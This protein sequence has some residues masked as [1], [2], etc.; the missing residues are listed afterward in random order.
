MTT[1]MASLQDKRFW[2][3]TGFFVLFVLAPPLDIL[4]F[5]LTLNHAILFGQ[6]WTLGIAAL[7]EGDITATEAVLNLVLRGFLPIFGGAA[8]FIWA[9]WRFGR[10]YCGW[11]CP[12]FSV[13]ELIN[14]LM[15][16]ASG[17]PSLWEKAPLPERR[18]DGSILKPKPLYWVPVFV[19]VFGMSLVWATALLTYLLPP[20]EVWGNL[21]TLDLTRNQ[22]LFIGVGTAVFAIEF[23]LARHLFC[24]FGCAVGLFQSLAWM[25]N[26]TAMV[27]GFDGRRAAEC[28]DCNAACDNACPMRLK[29]RSIKRRMFTCTQC[30]RCISACEDVQ[31]DNPQGSLLKWVQGDCARAVSEKD[32]GRKVEVPAGC[33]QDAPKDTAPPA[34]VVHLEPGVR[35]AMKR[36]GAA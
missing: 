24:R 28:A 15:L 19:T 5:D 13:V 12:H 10:L 34:Q 22:A 7:R 33:F 18:P 36:Q 21:F 20:L 26:R 16:R 9:A 27:V 25:A 29:P 31:A 8:L 23:I 2:I 17:K 35:K 6:P 14:G 4:R 32:F 1:T 30:A 11:L 3:R